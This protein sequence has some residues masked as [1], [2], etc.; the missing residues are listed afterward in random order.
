MAKV[1]LSFE[2]Q[3]R[4]VTRDCGTK[5]EAAEKAYQLTQHGATNIEGKEY[6][7]ITPAGLDAA[8]SKPHYGWQTFQPSNHCRR[9]G[10]ALS[11]PKSVQNGIGPE[12]IK[13][14]PSAFGSFQQPADITIRTVPMDIAARIMPL[15]WQK[16]C[17][18]CN[19]AL[20]PALMQYYEHDGGQTCPPIGD[21]RYW[22]FME[23]PTCGHQ[24]AFKHLNVSLYK[25][26][27]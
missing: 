19:T 13:K 10:R 25:L 23:C 9:C 6:T 2:F 11:D 20:T 7:K 5:A 21:K 1:K 18:F 16:D 26:A 14:L 22:F 8:Y 4:R 27:P 12:C 15:L 17:R 3:N 24:W